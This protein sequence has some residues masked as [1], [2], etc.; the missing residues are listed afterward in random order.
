MPKKESGVKTPQLPPAGQPLF[1]SQLMQVLVDR[2]A[3]YG[4]FE[5]SWDFL[6]NGHGLLEANPAVDPI[7]K[8]ATEGAKYAKADGALIEHN[9]YE[10]DSPEA[11]AWAE[12]FGQ[13]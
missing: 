10:K 12:A 5:V 9:P 6:T 7:E 2:M 3:A 4:D 13:E 1:A 8:A 11:K